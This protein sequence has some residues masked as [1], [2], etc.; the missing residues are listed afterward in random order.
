MATREKK[1]IYRI[2]FLNQGKL[3]EIYAKSVDQAAL[4]GFVEV[5]GLLFGERTTV[6]VDPAEESLKTEFAGV[7]RTFIPLHAVLRI[8]E[9][10]KRGASKVHSIEATGKVTPLPSPI[11]V[12]PRPKG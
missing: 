1:P 10:A 11:L 9:V 3:Y 6:L 4:L 7:E 2:L 8:D 12:P 5:E